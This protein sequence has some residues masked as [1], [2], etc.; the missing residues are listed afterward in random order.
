ML[1]QFLT[2]GRTGY[3]GWTNSTSLFSRGGGNFAERAVR[4]K[5]WW[6]RS[7]RCGCATATHNK[8]S[9]YTPPGPKLPPGD[10]IDYME[11]V[12]AI[13]H[14]ISAEANFLRVRL[15]RST[16]PGDLP[17][18]ELLCVVRRLLKKMN[19]MVLVGDRVRVVRVDWVDGRGMV[20][21]ILPRRSE[22]LDPGVANIDN[23]AVLVSATDP[24][25][26][27]YQVTRFLLAAEATSVPV[28]LV[29]NKV[30]LLEEGELSD[31]LERVRGWGYKPLPLSVSEGDG[32]KLVSRRLR[33][34]V[35]VV[36]GPSGV[37]KSSLINY[38][39]VRGR[40]R[41]KAKKHVSD[42]ATPQGDG[43]ET[44][45]MQEAN[46]FGS[47]S[48]REG[49]EEN[50]QGG[51]ESEDENLE[52]AS[53][54]ERNFNG[55][56]EDLEWV[57][58]MHGSSTGGE[59][60]ED[61]GGKLQSVQEVSSIGRGKHTT[62]TISFLDLPG[63]GLLADTPGFNLPDLTMVTL[64]NLPELFPEIELR[65]LENSCRFRNCSHIRE[66]GCVVRGEWER[67]PIYC[68]LYEETKQREKYE[69][70]HLQ[71]G[72]KAR[73]GTLKTKSGKGGEEKVEVKL[74]TKKFR[75][76]S[77][78]TKLQRLQ[79]LVKEETWDDFEDEEDEEEGMDWAYEKYTGRRSST[80][81]K[82]H[83]KGHSSYDEEY[84]DD[85]DDDARR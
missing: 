31:L 47:L 35:S 9:W 48:E 71:A 57:E 67:Y 17:R 7:Q 36:V 65:L 46:V 53:V 75:R 43:D 52:E 81:G 16:T 4:K 13:G 20:D 14:V 66:P 59:N 25:F 10:E 41:W 70:K 39:R 40:T 23:I 73:E 32:I 72:K 85:D 15:M 69:E 5:Q 34:R 33:N 58:A 22:L 26:D 62:R 3:V 54:E 49:H 1:K 21:E 61:E 6:R 82:N 38:L 76:P 55:T 63:G 80:A 2:F 44:S 29:I 12:E 50:E 19:R 56:N 8:G 18:E 83:R 64:K 51:G 42:S 24:P 60:L 11:P 68:T 28:T 77:R 30:D 45:A 84:S 74:D 27:A 79:D 37:G 78:R